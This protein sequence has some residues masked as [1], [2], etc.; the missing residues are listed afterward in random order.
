MAWSLAWNPK[1]VANHHYKFQPTSM[2]SCKLTLTSDLNS[3]LGKDRTSGDIIARASAIDPLCFGTQFLRQRTAQKTCLCCTQSHN[4]ASL[5]SSFVAFGNVGRGMFDFSQTNCLDSNAHRL[6]TVS[7]FLS[8]FLSRKE[9][10]V[11][12]QS[13]HLFAHLDLVS[14]TAT[15][16]V[17]LCFVRSVRKA[18]DSSDRPAR[19]NPWIEV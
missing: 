13:R 11:S 10:L 8:L 12:C 7:E 1:L 3:F 5:K 14:R 15:Q 4:V 6:R 18:F 2:M 16:R 19:Y 9:D 17:Y